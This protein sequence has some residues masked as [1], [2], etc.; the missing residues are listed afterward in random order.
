MTRKSAANQGESRRDRTYNSSQRAS[1]RVERMAA[2]WSTVGASWRASPPPIKFLIW[3]ITF[4]LA[5]VLVLVANLL[6]L[7]LPMRLVDL[8]SRV[9]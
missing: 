6:G 3:L 8:L 9:S 5:S 2:T 1:P 4:L 7:D